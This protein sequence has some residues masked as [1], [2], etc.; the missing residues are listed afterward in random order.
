MQRR[1][2]FISIFA[3]N[4]TLLQKTQKDG[5]PANLAGA[6][7]AFADFR[8]A[9]SVSAEQVKSCKNYQKAFY[10]D[11]LIDELH[12]A[13]DHNEAIVKQMDGVEQYQW[14]NAYRDSR[15]W[16]NIAEEWKSLSAANWP[17]DNVLV[18][19]DRHPRH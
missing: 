5:P 6:D 7:I 11:W 9:S 12:L 13:K 14:W 8:H 19:P 15:D 3:R 2:D 1:W 4:P 18:S 16:R 17:S 10:D